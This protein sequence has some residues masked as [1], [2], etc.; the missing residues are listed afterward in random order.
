M[1]ASAQEVAM[2]KGDM[3]AIEQANIQKKCWLQFQRPADPKMTA[4]A[5]LNADM[6]PMNRERAVAPVQ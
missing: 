5:P 2:L 6:T 1:P 3:E 4:T